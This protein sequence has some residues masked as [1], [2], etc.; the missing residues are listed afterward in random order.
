MKMQPIKEEEIIRLNFKDRIKNTL[1][2]LHDVRIKLFDR[3]KNTNENTDKE[4]F[5][6]NLLDEI[7]TLHKIL[8]YI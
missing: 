2:D 5:K 7:N 8:D 3:F 4:I 1:E 6:T